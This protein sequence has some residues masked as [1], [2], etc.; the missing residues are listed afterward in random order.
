MKFENIVMLVIFFAI[1]S[2]VG[3]FAGLFNY[4]IG[5]LQVN[6]ET[7]NVSIPTDGG[8]NASLNPN[9]TT[10]Q[11]VLGLTIYP[12]LE[13]RSALPYLTY[14][15]VFALIIAFSISAYLSSKYPLFFVVHLL[16]TLV[17]TY[18]AI[19][20]S[21]TYVDLLTNPFINSIML[22]FPIYNRLMYALPS[23]VFFPSL[24]FGIIA[25]IVNFKPSTPTSTSG[26][27]Y[28]GDY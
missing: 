20:I 10:L 14:F 28:G 6:L 17:M 26:L 12:F 1:I 22:D 15:L 11:D 24:L 8:V 25:F 3:L 7:I 5:V 23:I 18:F 13:L 27:N 2:F 21:N 16:F 4:G 9:M 19:I